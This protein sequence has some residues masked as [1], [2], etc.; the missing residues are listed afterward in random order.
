MYL[1]GLGY[2]RR[3]DSRAAQSSFRVVYRI[4]ARVVHIATFW[5]LQIK[6]A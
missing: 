4:L 5:W 1:R 2:C 6:F 3:L